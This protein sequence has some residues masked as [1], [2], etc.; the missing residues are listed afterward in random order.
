[1]ARR[2]LGPAALQV[3]RAVE[4]CLATLTASRVVLGVS[5]GA[6][7][8]ALAA[9]TAWVLRR[10]ERAGVDHEL[11]VQAVVVDH[12]L[13]AGSDEVAATVAGRLR[14]LGL[15]AGVVAV[16]VPSAGGR[17]PEAAARDARHAALLA[18][19]G[20]D[21]VVL[22]GHTLDD[23]AET[24][25]L[26]LGRGSGTR[27]LAG[28][29]PSTGALRRPLLGV[30]RAITREACRQWALPVWDDPHNAE[31]RFTRVRVRSRVLPSLEAELGPGVAE[32]LARTAALASTDADALDEWAA[33]ELTRELARRPSRPTDDG[34]LACTTLQALPA[35]IATRMVR[36]WLIGAGVDQPTAAHVAAV[37]GLVEN[38]HGQGAVHLPGAVVERHDGL[39]RV[40]PR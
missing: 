14:G 40:T 32:A 39:L 37:T 12:G 13:Q 17:G 27:S 3:A 31:A 23:Q 2:E 5:G 35:A 9:G 20:A 25:L 4:D 21:G 34:A 11:Q 10:F 28:M 19:A 26:G 33:R 22:L 36:A 1:M 7:S 6:D 29:K 15:E 18:A 24:V 16:E 8:M 30:R 38:W